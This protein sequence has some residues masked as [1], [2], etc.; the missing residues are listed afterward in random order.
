M[1]GSNPGY[2]LKS[3]L[4][5]DFGRHFLESRVSFF[6]WIFISVF[7]SMSSRLHWIYWFLPKQINFKCDCSF[8]SD[9][10]DPFWLGWR[11]KKCSRQFVKFWNRWNH[12][13]R[14]ELMNSS[15]F[16]KSWKDWKLLWNCEIMNSQNRVHKE[17]CPKVLWQC[18]SH[19]LNTTYIHT[20]VRYGPFMS[21]IFYD[22]SKVWIR[23]CVR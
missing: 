3:F 11:L 7:F 5:Y 14:H 8:W 23:D 1:M 13:M 9:F 22:L 18:K 20:W 4:L 17:F 6:A 19:S 12:V 21:L 10:E 16:E 15:F 2:I